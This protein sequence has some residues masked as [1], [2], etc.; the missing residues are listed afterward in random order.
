MSGFTGSETMASVLDAFLVET[1]EWTAADLMRLHETAA[2]LAMRR[3]GRVGSPRIGLPAALSG[4]YEAIASSP[5]WTAKER[6]VY[7]AFVISATNIR[8]ADAVYDGVAKG[9]FPRRVEQLDALM[10]EL[11]EQATNE[12]REQQ[13]FAMVWTPYRLENLAFTKNDSPLESRVFQ[14]NDFVELR[15]R[16]TLAEMLNLSVT[17]GVF[18]QQLTDR[19]CQLTRLVVPSLGCNCYR[20]G[21]TTTYEERLG[22]FQGLGLPGM[23]KCPDND[24]SGHPNHV[25]FKDAA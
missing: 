20:L 10:E 16:S 6:E 24:P 19:S 13:C 14:A 15:V 3:I 25:D 9:K 21:M 12:E 5:S 23:D 22:A 1:R 17:G 18:C 2:L 8:A 7:G 11:W 4:L